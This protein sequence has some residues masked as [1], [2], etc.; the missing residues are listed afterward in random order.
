MVH[1]RTSSHSFDRENPVQRKTLSSPKMSTSPFT[2]RASSE[3]QLS[4]YKL[5]APSF[6]PYG[7]TALVV[8][9]GQ[10]VGP[11]VVRSAALPNCEFHYPPGLTKWSRHLRD[12]GR[13]G[14]AHDE[15][16][17][18]AWNP[19]GAFA[20]MVVD[21]AVW[22]AIWHTPDRHLGRCGSTKAECPRSGTLSRMKPGMLASAG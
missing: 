20:S 4:D 1:F 16:V 2:H 8:E 21:R 19:I 18:R 3:H 17:P 15:H 13:V 5:V 10:I 9:V 22:R 7:Q 14:H 6:V 12:H 11:A